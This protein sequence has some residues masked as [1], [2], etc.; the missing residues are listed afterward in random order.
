VT[1][2]EAA[3]YDVPLIRDWEGSQQPDALEHSRGLPEAAANC[4]PREG[5]GVQAMAPADQRGRSAGAFHF[6]H[7]EKLQA[8]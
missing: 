2:L 4:S 8:E 5:A 1:S 3:D 7:Q 6:E